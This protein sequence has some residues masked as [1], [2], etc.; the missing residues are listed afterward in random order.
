[1]KQYLSNLQISGDVK[2]HM[3]V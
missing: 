2:V 3:K 1:M